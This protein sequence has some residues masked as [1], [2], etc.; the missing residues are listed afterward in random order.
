M[1]FAYVQDLN[2]LGNRVASTFVAALPVIAIRVERV[3]A[4]GRID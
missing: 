2:P 1:L 4:W 3:A